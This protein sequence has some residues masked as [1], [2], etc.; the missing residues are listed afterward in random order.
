[1]TAN[2][3]PPSLSTARAAAAA[4][5][6]SAGEAANR[7]LYRPNLAG[8]HVE[9][10]FL[11]G[12]SP[13]G[14]RALWLKYTLLAP[15]AGGPAVA[16]LWAIAFDRSWPAPRANKRTY[17]IER[18]Q[19]RSA[20]FGLSL[21][22][23]ELGHGHAR[24]VLGADDQGGPLLRW[25]LRYACPEAP[26]LPF[27]SPRMYT[28]AFPRTKTLT[29]V[30]DTLLE[31]SFQVDEQRWDVSGFRAAQ[32]HN[33]GKGHAH[34][35]AW[36]HA[37][38]LRPRPGSA[39]CSH[40]WLEV[41]SGR[42]RVGPLLTPWLTVA[43]IELDGQLHRF[44]GPRAMLS[45]AVESDARSFAF[46]V[47]QGDA[48]LSAKL[49]AELPLL[50]GLRYQDPDGQELAC[51]NSKLAYGEVTMTAHGRTWLLGTDQAAL[52]LGTRR[53]DHGVPLLV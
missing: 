48:T 19:L 6:E 52:E 51:L 37:N 15:K 30:P 42:V 8:G 14:Q 41:I 47:R 31:G 7:L 45:R 49:W 33:W 5:E 32:G 12:N 50:A 40:A 11:K 44:D 27:P 20:P 3:E 4:P 35:Y 53:R 38:A 26:F 13:D 17:P 46:S 9:S 39:P 25:E 22:D 34:A 43:A 2:H 36:A 28:G 23:G 29:P 18:A 1:M 16:E 10:L 21:P 24:G